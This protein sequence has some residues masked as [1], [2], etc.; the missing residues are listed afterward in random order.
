MDGWVQF[1]CVNASPIRSPSRCKPASVSNVIPRVTDTDNGGCI[2]DVDDDDNDDE[3]D[4]DGNDNDLNAERI[5][6]LT[7]VNGISIS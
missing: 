2:C 7:G 4:D 3:R 1:P 6:R 5:P